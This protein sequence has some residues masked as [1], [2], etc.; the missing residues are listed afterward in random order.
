MSLP[1]N[2]NSSFRGIVA[3]EMHL[4]LPKS[5]DTLLRKLRDGFD[6][7]YKDPSE[8][9]SSTALGGGE[10]KEGGLTNEGRDFG[11][12]S[13]ESHGSWISFTSSSG[14]RR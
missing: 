10:G 13:S 8:R 14:W 2:L 12:G 3:D 5:H 9:V 1:P 4:V 6:N 11:D 7:F